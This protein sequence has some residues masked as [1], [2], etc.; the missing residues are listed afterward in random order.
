MERS[1]KPTKPDTVPYI[2]FEGEIAR[3]ERH[4]K[5]LWIA[6]I[7]AIVAASVAIVLIVGG[8]LLYLNQYDFASYQQDGEGVNIVGDGNGVDFDGPASTSATQEEQSNSQGQS[9]PQSP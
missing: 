4:I 2:V 6:L 8:F 9:D 7:T 3:Q 5:R 1:N